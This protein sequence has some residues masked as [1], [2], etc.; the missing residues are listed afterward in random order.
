MTN[1]E[2]QELLKQYPDDM[3]I[4]TRGYEA[5]YVDPS[6]WIRPVVLDVHDKDEWYY[7]PHEYDNEDLKE[8][9]PNHV[10]LKGIYIG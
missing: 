7:G 1:K 2:L 8:K 3:R 9:K 6:F 10:R 4:F 5:G